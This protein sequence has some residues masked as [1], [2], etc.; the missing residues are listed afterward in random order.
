MV[1]FESLQFQKSPDD[2]DIKYRQQ[3]R[4]FFSRFA[5]EHWGAFKL[6]EKYKLLPRGVRRRDVDAKGKTYLSEKGNPSMHCLVEAVAADI[7]G[8]ELEAKLGLRAEDVQKLVQAGL[9]H[10]VTKRDDLK[11]AREASE[12]GESAAIVFDNQD[13]EIRTVLS[14]AGVSED[15]GE[16]CESVGHTSLQ[17]M[18][19]ILAKAKTE[20]LSSQDRLRL[21]FHYLDDIT[22]NDQIVSLDKRMK[23]LEDHSLPP[24]QSSE[25]FSSQ[26]YELNERGRQVFDGKTTF[27]V[28]REVGE[29]VQAWLAGELGLPDPNSLPVF[30]NNKIKD[31][32]EQEPV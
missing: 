10:D 7:L 29:E 22:A 28:Q 31:R 9:L 3:A 19:K 8:K 12:R 27:E 25:A 15:L 23:Y 17:D 16:L 1:K 5:R 21:V 26:Y 6:H 13:K 2:P 32:I 14:E 20:T 18:L 24:G 30:I 11:R 4:I